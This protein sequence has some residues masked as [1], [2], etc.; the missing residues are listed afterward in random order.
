MIQQSAGKLRAK[1]HIEF[2]SP[3]QPCSIS[4]IR[5]ACVVGGRTRK[6]QFSKVIRDV[7]AFTL[8]SIFLP[9]YPA[10]SERPKSAQPERARPAG[11]AVPSARRPGRKATRSVPGQR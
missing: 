2:S 1:T 7:S 4:K 10:Q 5:L 9:V 11:I 8:Y 3:C 6:V